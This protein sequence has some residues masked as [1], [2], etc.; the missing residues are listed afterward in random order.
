MEVEGANIRAGIVFQKVGAT[1]L[2]RSQPLVSIPLLLEK[3]QLYLCPNTLDVVR[4]KPPQVSRIII[5][6]NLN[7][8]FTFPEQSMYSIST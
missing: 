6:S 4:E 3:L 2:P 5:I 8:D 1:T 7:K